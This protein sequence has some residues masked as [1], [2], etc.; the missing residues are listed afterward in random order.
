MI[1]GDFIWRAKSHL[2]QNR[3]TYRQHFVF[4][5]GHGLRCLMAA[6]YLIIHAIAPCFFVR[7]G[8]LLVERMEKDFTDHRKSNDD[9]ARRQP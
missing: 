9:Q 3:M 7:A 1:V 6:A 8:S 2:S 5:G 4:A